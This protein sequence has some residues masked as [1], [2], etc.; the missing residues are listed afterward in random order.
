LLKRQT[1]FFAKNF[2]PPACLLAGLRLNKFII[3][4][5]IAIIAHYG[6][7]ADMFQFII[8]NKAYFNM[9]IRICDI[10]NVPLATN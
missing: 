2:A 9:L 3:T 5:E 10:H 6:K 7:K 1:F 8:K 4:M